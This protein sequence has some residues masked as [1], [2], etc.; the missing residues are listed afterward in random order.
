MSQR[1]WREIASERKEKQEDSIP[2]KWRISAPSVDV[3]DVL[4]IPESC[5]ILTDLELR[6]TN[7]LDVE[8]LLKKLASGEWTS[9]AVTTA[10]YKRA[11]IAQQLVSERSRILHGMLLLKSL[12]SRQTA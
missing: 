4:S 9:V 6:I 7:T 11:I 8:I 1:T 12:D 3:L 10:F 2:H 5:G